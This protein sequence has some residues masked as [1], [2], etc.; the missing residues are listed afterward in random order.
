MRRVIGLLLVVAAAVGAFMLPEPAPDEGPTFTGA[1]PPPPE[2]SADAST[3]YCTW[4]DSGDVRDSDYALAALPDV[5]ATVTLPSP[6]LNEDADVQD[7][8]ITGPGATLLDVDD[9]VR[10]G[11]APGIVEFDGGPAAAAATVTSEFSLSGDLCTRSISKVWYLP[12]LTTRTGRVATLRLFNPFREPAKANVSGV[13]EFGAVPLPELSPIDVAGRSWVDVQLNPAIPFFDDLALIIES[14]QGNVVPAVSL[15]SEGGDE[16]SWSGSGL[17]A[18]WDYPLVRIGG[19]AP[20]LMVVNPGAEPITVELDVVSLDG[21]TSLAATF[22]VSGDAP[23][24]VPLGDLADGP[25]GIRVRA[26]APVATAVVAETPVVVEESSEEAV[27]TTAP[28]EEEEVDPVRIAGT[29]GIRQLAARWLLPGAGDAPEAIATV[30]VMNPGSEP[31]TITLQP[32]GTVDFDAEKVVVDPGTL[33]RFDLAPGSGASAHV[34]DS[35][36]PVAVGW[37]LQADR[38]IAYVAGAALVE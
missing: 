26:A 27:T 21:F 22:E 12:G 14:E 36:Q 9:I 28:P 37:T 15:A 2:L 32:L 19:L 20:D 30:W 3:W 8:S 4:V 34:V 18:T 5:L 6:I 13:S 25:F 16:A 11:A 1:V 17:S 33:A 24:R 29:T 23:A 31:A 7:M 38:G 35:S 10:L